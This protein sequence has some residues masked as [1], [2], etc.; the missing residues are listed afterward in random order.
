MKKIITLIAVTL[1]FISCSSD[2]NFYG[3]QE[4]L[5]GTWVMKSYKLNDFDTTNKDC[6]KIVIN[7]DGTSVWTDCDSK[8]DENLIFKGL[9]NNVNFDVDEIEFKSY[10]YYCCGRFISENEIE[11]KQISTHGS[12]TFKY[13]YRFVKNK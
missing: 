11:F 5:T 13:I 2:D 8:I 3:N 12:D 1:L 4:D 6:E 10:V 7:A 9:E